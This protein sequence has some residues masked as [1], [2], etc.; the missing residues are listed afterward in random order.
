MKI[1]TK[2]V[3]D[4]RPA[5]YNPRTI[6]DKARKHLEA[7]IER[8]GMVQPIVWNKRT[9]NI[10]G[11]HQRLAVLQ[12]KGIEKVK[13]VEVDLDEAEEIQL[14]L[15]MNNPHAQG[16]FDFGKLESLKLSLESLDVPL[17]ELE[18][19]GLLDI[20]KDCGIVE[21]EKPNVGP[22]INNWEYQIIIECD[23]EEQQAELLAQFIK[24]GLTCRASIL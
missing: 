19:F 4:L 14:N 6:T 3:N 2:L 11:G 23:S 7:S 13:V 16:T 8:F 1:V 9:G 18:D 20:F 17:S 22:Q 12:K 21:K 5:D 15:A 10:V 24:E